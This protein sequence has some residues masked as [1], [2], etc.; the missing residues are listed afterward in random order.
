MFILDL[1]IAP[2]VPL[3]VNISS[4]QSDTVIVRWWRPLNFTKQIDM[5]HLRY[6]VHQEM[7]YKKLE[8]KHLD[9]S[10]DFYEVNVILNLS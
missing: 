7:F 5:Y 8:L 1:V 10:Q 6:R 4:N 2:G 3:L 9:T